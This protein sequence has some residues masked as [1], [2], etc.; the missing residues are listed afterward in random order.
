M[1]TTYIT[2]AQSQDNPLSFMLGEYKGTGWFISEEGKK[3]S[4]ITEKV[5]CKQGCSFIVVEGL[6]TRQDAIGKE[7][8]SH[9]AYGII[10]QDRKTEKWMIQAYRNGEVV[11][12]EIKLVTDKIIRWE[13][14]LP[15]NAGTVRFTTDFSNPN[16]WKGIGEYSKDNESWSQI[17]ETN[18]TKIVD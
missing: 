4:N 18:L 2:F 5:T 1:N 15:N 14:P 7:V 9:E 6:G 11:I 3:E 13:L 12:A 17:M 8:I 10:T 16:E